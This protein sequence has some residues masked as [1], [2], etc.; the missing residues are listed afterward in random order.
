VQRIFIA[1]TE[2]FVARYW[3]SLSTLLILI[4]IFIVALDIAGYRYGAQRLA[5]SYTL[6]LGTL[7]VL[8]RFSIRQSVQCSNP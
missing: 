3:S 6:S 1:K 7:M 5:L 4:A 2:G 8:C